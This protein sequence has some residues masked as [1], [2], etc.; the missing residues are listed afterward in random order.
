MV[1]SPL[2]VCI[3][4]SAAW[5]PQEAVPKAPFDALLH[6]LLAMAT[7]IV[8]AR[9]VGF[10]FARL[11]QPP[12]MGEVLA[13]ILLGPSLL[14]RVA[15]ETANFLLPPPVAPYLG[16]LAQLGVVLYMFLVGLELDLAQ[17][18]KRPQATVTIAQASIVVPFALG[19]A[20]AW[21]LHPQLGLPG[22][23]PLH[24]VLF[25]GVAMSITAFPVLARI[26][27]D[28]GAHR[29]ALGVMALACAAVSDVTA[30]C[31]LAFVVALVHS[32]AASGLW[33]T[34]WVVVYIAVML[35]VVRPGLA[36][37]VAAHEQAGRFS[38]NTLA[39][40]LTALL[41]SALATEAIGVHAL[42]GAFLLGALVP[43]HSAMARE[44]TGKLEDFVVVLFLPAFFAHTGM[45][46]EIGLLQTTSE[47]LLCAAIIVVACLGKF[48]GTFLAA[49]GNGFDGRGAMALGVLMNTR[50]LMELIVLNIGLDLGILSPQLFAMFVVMALVTTL[51][52]TP[53]LDRLGRGGSLWGRD[54]AG[55][56]VA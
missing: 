6:V 10:L 21:F 20:M 37:L 44:L 3:A 45:R 56:G 27:T 25:F 2:D 51:M 15:P 55:G 4:A 40:I 5:S 54:A 53:L 34:L 12:V 14:G 43:A 41:L 11:R 42:F 38:R 9:G 13:G 7:V 17:L 39:A 35:G 1:S 48:G 29:S 16:V 30:W 49:R 52:T 19:A 8:A 24:F 28:R 50:G 33:T 36:R 31:L 47:W 22:V 26:L 32:D 46:T 23:P 18:R